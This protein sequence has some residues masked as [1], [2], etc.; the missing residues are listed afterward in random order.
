LQGFV[1]DSQGAAQ[2]HIRDRKI[3]C[4]LITHEYEVRQDTLAAFLDERGN[5]RGCIPSVRLAIGNDE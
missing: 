4:V 5:F 2:T 1:D 3:V